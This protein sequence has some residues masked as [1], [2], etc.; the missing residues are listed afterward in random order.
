MSA[1]HSNHNDKYTNLDEIKRERRIDQFLEISTTTIVA[2]ATIFF[3]FV[4]IATS[5][6]WLPWKINIAHM[7]GY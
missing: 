3:L 5:T 2:V 6:D 1:L 4:I 7:L